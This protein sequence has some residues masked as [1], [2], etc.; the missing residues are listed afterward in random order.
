MASD[1]RDDFWGFVRH[2]VD[3]VPVVGVSMGFRGR[4]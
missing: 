4:G 1:H 3:T 2:R